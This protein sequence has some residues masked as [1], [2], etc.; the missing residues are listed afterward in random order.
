MSE[1]TIRITKR[2]KRLGLPWKTTVEEIDLP[3]FLL[4]LGK[5]LLADVTK[6]PP[7]K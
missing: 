1:S 6:G 5:S 3:P 4:E 7:S 2:T